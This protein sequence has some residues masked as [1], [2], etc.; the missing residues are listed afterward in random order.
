M[1]GE[2]AYSALAAGDLFCLGVALLLLAIALTAC[3][4]GTGCASTMRP[5][6]VIRQLASWDGTNQNSGF[7]CFT[8]GGALITAHARE[9][10]NA[11][12]KSYGARFQPALQ[13]D[14]G[15]RAVDE[16]NGSNGIYW[17]DAEHLA[18][19]ATMNRWRRG[20]KP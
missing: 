12:V 18:D 5:A 3:V 6:P 16:K 14:A 20:E 4:L 7:I 1:R 2:D 8:N 13:E 9:R 11:L 15:I 17:I 10:Y 19:F